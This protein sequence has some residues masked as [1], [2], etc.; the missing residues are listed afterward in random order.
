VQQSGFDDTEYEDFEKEAPV[1]MSIDRLGNNI[2]SSKA[3]T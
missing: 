2:S 3:N 1:M